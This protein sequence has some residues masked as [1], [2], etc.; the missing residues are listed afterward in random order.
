[1][2]RVTELVREGSSY[3]EKTKFINKAAIISVTEDSGV[4]KALAEQRGSAATVSR[5]SLNLPEGHATLF[6]LG[7]PDSIMGTRTNSK[8]SLLHG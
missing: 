4:S 2:L 3:F 6:V 1:M 8:G 7:S 5:I